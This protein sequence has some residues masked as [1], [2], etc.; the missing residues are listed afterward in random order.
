MNNCNYIGRLTK[1]PVLR[2]TTGEEQTCIASYTIAV[3]RIYDR[4]NADFIQCE[5]WGTKGTFAE[6]YFRRG[7]KVAVSG[8]TRT[9][10]YINKQGQKVYTS[11]CRV[12]NQEFTESKSGNTEEDTGWM[13]IPEGM[14]EE[15]PFN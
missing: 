1:D 8:Q 3:D 7:M 12:E 10:S 13:N 4:G 2:Y 5:A 15:L 9:G 11:V 6:K 14:D